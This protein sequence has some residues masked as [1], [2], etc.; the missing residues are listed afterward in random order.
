MTVVIEM[1]KGYVI[2]MTGLPCSGKTTIANELAKHIDCVVLDGDEV[3]KTISSDLGFSEVDRWKHLMRMAHIAKFLSDRG[4]NVIA[5]FITP[6]QEIR[7]GVA[8][9]IG[10]KYIEVYVKARIETCMDRDVKGMWERARRGEIDNFTG[11]Q[12]PYDIPHEPDVI[13]DTDTESV[14]SSV[15]KILTHLNGKGRALFIGR[16]QPFHDGHKAIIQKRLDDGFPIAIGVRKMY[17][18]NN[19]PFTAE[20]VKNRIENEYK[21]EDVE[22]FIMP[23]ISS[24]NYGRRVGYEITQITVDGDI[25]EISATRIRE[26][27]NFE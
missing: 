12:S 2:W 21:D 22:V 17:K 19:N 10:A 8:S 16:F 27:L 13:C 24:V 23:N 4:Q 5:S 18:D 9:I 15:Q 6:Q 11:V 26:E 3:R 1:K 14:E 7:D 25:E 20:E